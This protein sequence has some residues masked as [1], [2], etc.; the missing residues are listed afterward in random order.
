MHVFFV[1]LDRLHRETSSNDEA[2]HP[3]QVSSDPV[4]T[5][6]PPVLLPVTAEL[7]LVTNLFRCLVECK[8]F[9]YEHE[10][11]WVHRLMVA[12]SPLLLS[13]AV[14]SKA[15]SESCCSK[16]QTSEKNADGVVVFVFVIVV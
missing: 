10:R 12:Q 6:C 5:A 15:A 1:R 3:L 7:N 4:Q 2:G 14:C 8:R 13:N 9:I 16:R 11:D